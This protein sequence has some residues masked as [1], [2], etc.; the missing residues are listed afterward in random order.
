[1]PDIDTDFCYR[2]RQEVIDYVTEKY[3]KDQVAQIVTFGTMAA[4]L[5]IR[6]V[7]RAMDLPYNEVDTI[8]KMVPMEKDMTIALALQKNPELKELYDQDEV[9]HKLI[10]MSQRLE[11]LPRHTSTHA[12]GV[13]ISRT[14]TVEYVPLCTN[15][16]NV[17]TQFTK[18]TLEELGL[19][20]MD[21][22]GLRTLTVIQDALDNI[23]QTE[24]KKSISM[25]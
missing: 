17:V 11:G 12:A 5:V 10:D 14:A 8:A 2:R 18:D 4:R 15:D 16:G 6:D 3:G 24:H 21:F 25:R 20:K 1:M 22:L 13:L 23:E 19:L 7:G 9:I